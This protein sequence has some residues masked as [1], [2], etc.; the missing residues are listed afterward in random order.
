MSTLPQSSH[1]FIKAFLENYRT[2]LCY[3]LIMLKNMLFKPIPSLLCHFYC[4]TWTPWPVISVILQHTKSSLQKTC[5]AL[6]FN[7]IVSLDLIPSERSSLI[8]YHTSW[9]GNLQLS[10]QWSLI[11]VSFDFSMYFLS[12]G[13]HYLW[14]LWSYSKQVTPKFSLS[15]SQVPS[16]SIITHTLCVME[17]QIKHQEN[18][19]GFFSWQS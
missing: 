1:L 12:S 13:E 11:P 6:P 17:P 3:C 16:P 18:C 15:H 5:S 19:T 7:T 2:S 9:M 14:F 10:P 8:H 4:A